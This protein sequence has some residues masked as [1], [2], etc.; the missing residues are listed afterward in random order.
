MNFSKRLFVTAMATLVLL[1]A[2]G[3]VVVAAEQTARLTLSNVV[4]DSDRG[5]RLNLSRNGTTDYAIVIA[6]EAHDAEEY[7]AKELAYFLKKMTGAEFSIRRDDA[8]PAEREI[9]LGNTNR[10]QLADLP[11]ELR[12]DNWEGFALVREGD[13]LLIMGNIPRG[14]LYGVYDFLD[15]ELGVRFLAHQVNHVPRN[16]TL[17]VPVASRVYGP[18]L[19]RRTIWEGG[20]MGDATVRNRMNG[21]SFQI[22]NEKMLGGVKMVGRPTHTFD[23]F[24]PQ[25]EYFTEHPEYFAFVDGKRR[26]NHNGMITQLCLTNPDVLRLSLDV[27]RAWLQEAREQNPYNKYI[28]SVSSNDS[29]HHCQCEPCQAVNREEGVSSGSGGTH[30]RFLNAIANDV[31][32]DFP[33]ASVKTMFYHSELPKKTRPARNVILENVTGVDWRYPLDDLSRNG[34]RYMTGSLGKWRQTVGDGRL[35]IWSKHGNFGDFISKGTSG[36]QWLVPNPNLRYIARNIRVMSEQFGVIGMFAQSTQSA[37]TDFQTLRYYLM[38]RAMW[39]PTDDS[40]DQITEFCRLYYGKGAKDVLRY[41]DYLHDDFG[42]V[43]P[44]KQEEDRPFTL[45]DFEHFIET[46]DPMLARAESRADNDEVKL[47]VATLRLSTWKTILNLA[48][49]DLKNDRSYVPSDRVR[50][51]GRRFIEV[52]RAARLTHLSEAYSGH[53][54]QTERSY[55]RR[56]RELLRRGRPEDPA[57]PWIS[58]DVGLARADLR[59]ARRLDLCGSNVT[60]A[61]LAYLSRLAQLESIDLRYTHVTDK[62]LVHL[63]G[64]E[65]LTELLLGGNASNVGTKI[66]DHGVGYLRN[67]KNLT[68]LSLARTKVSNDAV[69][70]ILGMPRLTYLDLSGTGVH[71]EGLADLATMTELEHLDVS[72]AWVRGRVC[73]TDAGV[74]PLQRLEKLKYLNLYD[75]SVTDDGVES[76]IR[77]RPK[78]HIRRY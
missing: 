70:V 18:P 43:F 20:L 41:I 40:Q 4:L 46:A 26:D 38:A 52:G 39:R 58:D 64:L 77:A 51:A 24:V 29:I 31:A 55:Y 48:F 73:V 11:A 23:S 10:R 8:S 61:G 47:R 78:L 32:Q 75:T 42:E 33:N 65:N 56:I 45:A 25:A 37:A 76:L 30:V 36:A 21:I 35:Y 68:K 53:N 69:A 2:S 19:E 9:V 14:T 66:T 3:D 50:T 28:V 15:V 67:M 74:A 6:A 71:E 54:A 34:A 17:R 5:P 13:R 72:G 49:E 63:Q 16:R 62:G 1:H 57:N 22:V 60:D 44:S 59:R 7:A 12:I 27:V